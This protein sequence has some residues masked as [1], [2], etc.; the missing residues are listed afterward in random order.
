[1]EPSQTKTAVAKTVQTYGIFFI[2]VFLFIIPM[3]LAYYLNHRPG[4]WFRQTKNKG[5]LIQPALS[6]KDF[7]VTQPGGKIFQSANLQGHWNLLY[8]SGE[9]CKTQCQR[10]MYNMRQLHIA[11]GKNMSRVKRLIATFEEQ[12]A[13]D[14]FLQKYTIDMSH[15]IVAKNQFAE[16]T[17]HTHLRKSASSNGEIFIIDPHGN[18]IMSYDSGVLPDDI[19]DDLTHLLKVSRIG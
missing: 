17:S 6:L 16:R 11:L 9:E 8:V 7:G 4:D 2:I 19:Y 3:V 15:L 1:V 18:I 5:H 12:P 14:K 13:L 10:T